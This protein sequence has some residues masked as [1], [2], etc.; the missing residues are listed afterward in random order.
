METLVKELT[1]K[2]AGYLYVTDAHLNRG[3]LNPWSRLPSYW[4]EEV[5]AVA[6]ANRS[7]GAVD[8]P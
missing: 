7:Q 1:G 2:S 6:R 4:K 3:V 8:G 5:E